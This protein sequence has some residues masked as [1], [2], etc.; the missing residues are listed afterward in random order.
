MRYSFKDKNMSCV[1]DFLFF[2]DAINWTALFIHPCIPCMM[3]CFISG[4]ETYNSLQL[5]QI[6]L[7]TFSSF[8]DLS[9]SWIIKSEIKEKTGE[10]ERVFLLLFCSEVGTSW[11][12]SASMFEVYLFLKIE[13]H[14][15]EF[16]CTNPCQVLLRYQFVTIKHFH[17]LSLLLHKSIQMFL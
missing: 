15:E 13:G 9:Q 2:Q 17:L 1:C 4:S 8:K 11:T 7:P 6:V 12:S 5:E 3:H 16:K 10:A 14:R